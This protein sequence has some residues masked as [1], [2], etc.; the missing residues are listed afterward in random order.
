MASIVLRLPWGASVKHILAAVDG[1][2]PSKKA[3]RFAADL[4]RLTGARLSLLFVLEPQTIAP[5][6]PMDFYAVTKAETSPETIRSARAVLD[7][8]ARGLPHG[9]VEPMLE[10]GRA[11]ETIL[12]RATA[13][14]VDHI[15]VGARGLGAGARWLLGSVSDRVVHHALC[16]VTVVR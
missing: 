5:F 8:V 16:P 7:E 10:I 9:Q 11:A 6:A 1:S 4:A 15:V 3:A 13:M 14:S 2:E 12:D